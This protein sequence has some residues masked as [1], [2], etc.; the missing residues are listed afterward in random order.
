MT[1]PATPKGTPDSFRCSRPKARQRSLIGVC[2][3]RIQFSYD[4]GSPDRGPGL[5][6]PVAE[7]ASSPG[8]EVIARARRLDASIPCRA[9]RD[10]TDLGSPPRSTEGRAARGG[11]RFA[12]MSDDEQTQELLRAR[13][14]IENK[15][16]VPFTDAEWDRTLRNPWELAILE[17]GPPLPTAL[18]AA[19]QH[20][21][22]T[23][24]D[25]RARLDAEGIVEKLRKLGFW[26]EDNDSNTHGISFGDLWSFYN[27]CGRSALDIRL[28]QQARDHRRFASAAKLLRKAARELRWALKAAVPFRIGTIVYATTPLA[29]IHMTELAHAA[30]LIDMPEKMRAELREEA[31][32]NGE[33]PD[34]VTDFA[35]IL[36]AFGEQLHPRR[37]GTYRDQVAD[38]FHEAWQSFALR[39][40]GSPLKDV[41]TYMLKIV[42][43]RPAETEAIDVRSLAKQRKRAESRRTVANV[44]GR[45]RSS[46]KSRPRK[47]PT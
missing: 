2:G 45:T 47:E 23:Q 26:L 18:Q 46:R 21:D 42:L 36:A 16:G 6:S 34:C 10:D 17:T 1:L 5:Q 15:R 9:N 28:A 14:A 44:L 29:P 30:D 33:N 43:G 8:V 13:R 7:V 12:R 35:R 24:P 41:A 19:R 37:P 22:L 39:H 11:A 32:R 40:T 3:S 38:R 20:F 31:E 4:T 27:D 25:F